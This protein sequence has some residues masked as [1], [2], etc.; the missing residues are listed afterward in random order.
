VLFLILGLVLFIPLVE[1]GRL[2]AMVVF[3][4]IMAL[5]LIGGLAGWNLHLPVK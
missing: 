1:N 2:A 3:V 5:W 4:V